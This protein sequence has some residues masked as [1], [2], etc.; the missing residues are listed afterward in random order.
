MTGSIHRKLASTSIRPVVVASHQRSGTHL[1]LDLLRRQFRECDAW[2][3]PGEKLSRL[4]VTL[5]AIENPAVESPLTPKQVLR[6]LER[7]ERPLIKT[8]MVL[9]RLFAGKREAGGNLDEAWIAWLERQAQ[10]LY[11]HRDVREVMCSLLLFWIGHAPATR[12]STSLSE[13]IRQLDGSGRNRVSAWSDHVRAHLDDPRVQSIAFRDVLEDTA[14]TVTDLGEF[15]HC[16]PRY[17]MPLLPTRTRGIWRSRLARIVSWRP[18][19]TTV[20]G[21]PPGVS[22]PRWRDALTRDDRIFVHEHAGDVL[23]RLGYESSDS[24][25]HAE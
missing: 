24:W 17:R 2:K 12:S 6:I 14:D 9:P 25:I 21:R 16:K 13:F 19:A 18:V 22:L 5:E 7:C 11:V 8:H 23:T 1:L 3:L 20:L 15:I 4:Y 10:I